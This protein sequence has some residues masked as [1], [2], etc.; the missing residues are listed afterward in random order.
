MLFRSPIDRE[1][2]LNRTG[3]TKP[4]FYANERF[5]ATR[6]NNFLQD[7]EAMAN[8]SWSGLPG[9]TVEDAVVALSQGAVLDRS[10]E[11]LVPA[12]LAIVRARRLLLDSIQRVGEGQDPIGLAPR[13]SMQIRSAEKRMSRRDSWHALVPGHLPRNTPVQYVEPATLSAFRSR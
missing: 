2:L 4:G 13:N 12:D 7:R 9:I 6:E 1:A 11:N 8:G 5:I 3:L 10:K